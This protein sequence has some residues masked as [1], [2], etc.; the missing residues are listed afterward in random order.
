MHLSNTYK[1]KISIYFQIFHT[2]GVADVTNYND[3]LRGGKIKIRARINHH[4]QKY[5]VHH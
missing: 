3:G 4:E 2:G 1:E 5:V